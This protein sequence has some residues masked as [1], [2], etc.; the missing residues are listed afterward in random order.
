MDEVMEFFDRALAIP[1]LIE[2]KQNE[3][4][5]IKELAYSLSAID[6]SG[7]RVST[8]RN[9]SCKYAELI[10]KAADLEAELLDDV[11]ELMDYQRRV[12]KVVDKIPE[13]ICR[14]V[15]RYLYIDRLPVKE[16]A[17]KL[18]RSTRSIYGLREKSA[19]YCTKLCL[20]SPQNSL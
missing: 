11:Q 13:P 5:R 18:N 17:K 20:L 19:Q 8:S 7:E 14:A 10:N 15:M 2:S 1:E 4:K 3:I 16:V 9:T 6:N 12:G